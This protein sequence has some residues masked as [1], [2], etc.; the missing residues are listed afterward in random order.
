MSALFLM[1]FQK[2]Y[3]SNRVLLYN[4]DKASIIKDMNIVEI[5]Q[6]HSRGKIVSQTFD[7]TPIEYSEF[8]FPRLG[9]ENLSLATGHPAGAIHCHS[10]P[11]VAIQ[12]PIKSLRDA[13]TATII[14]SP[15]APIVILFFYFHLKKSKSNQTRTLTL[16]S[17]AAPICPLCTS[18]G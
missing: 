3:R 13:R 8:A 16:S 14:S 11:Y 17:P 5:E 9:P 2:S 6:S 10:V 7:R 15:A 12:L 18:S 4:N 1:L